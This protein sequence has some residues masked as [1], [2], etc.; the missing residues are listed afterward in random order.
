MDHGQDEV[1]NT[2]G[3]DR[4]IEDSSSLSKKKPA[5]K[6]VVTLDIKPWDDT[7]DLSAL[8]SSVRTIQSDGLVWGASQLLPLGFGIQKL[9]IVLVVED[10]KVSVTELQEQIEKLEDL[11]QSTDV[12]SMQKL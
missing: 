10:E 2:A 3:V 8:E 5:A 1:V 12:V 9:Q 6:S 4:S 7:T 11:V